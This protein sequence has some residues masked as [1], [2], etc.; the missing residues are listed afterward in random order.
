MYK[1]TTL[2]IILIAATLTITMA[3]TVNAVIVQP[4]FAP[5][6]SCSSCA[7]TFT[8]SAL[9]SGLS[10]TGAHGVAKIFAPGQEAQVGGGS[11]SD[12]APG[13]EKP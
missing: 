7:K 13:H 2:G 12:F 10:G 8:P 3:L 11:A 9:S 4:V 6:G 5:T 1:P